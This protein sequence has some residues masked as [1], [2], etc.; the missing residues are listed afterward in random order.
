MIT[1]LWITQYALSFSYYH[2][3][4]RGGG[5][6]EV[7]LIEQLKTTKIYI[8]LQGIGTRVFVRVYRND[9]CMQTQNICR[10]L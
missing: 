8:N 6:G 7:T 5:G 4:G 3:G 9:N 10:Y 1:W 2:G